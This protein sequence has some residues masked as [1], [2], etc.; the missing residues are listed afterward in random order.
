M[1]GILELAFIMLIIAGLAFLPLGYFIYMYTNKGGEPFGDIEPHGDSESPVLKGAEK[2][3]QL[4]K[5]K[6]KK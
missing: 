3:I 2:L 6:I 4:V 1:G 5:S